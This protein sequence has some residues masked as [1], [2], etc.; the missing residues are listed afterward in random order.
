MTNEK[1]N[2][3]TYTRTIKLFNCG[4]GVCERNP[5]YQPEPQY[6]EFTG[7]LIEQLEEISPFEGKA[8]FSSEDKAEMSKRKRTREYYQK[9]AESIQKNNEKDD[10]CFYRMMQLVKN[11]TAGQ[12][13]L[14]TFVLLAK[15]AME[16]GLEISILE[17]KKRAK[18]ERLKSEWDKIQDTLGK[19]K[20]E[21]ALACSIGIRENGWFT[22]R[23][24]SIADQSPLFAMLSFLNYLKK[25]KWIDK[26]PTSN[27]NARELLD[28][29]L[30]QPDGVEEVFAIYGAELLEVYRASLEMPTKTRTYRNDHARGIINDQWR[31]TKECEGSYVGKAGRG[32]VDG[33]EFDRRGNVKDCTNPFNNVQVD[34]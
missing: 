18:R 32:F 34:F 15:Y 20:H 6:C 33:I 10:E 13:H 16:Q 5:N 9:E 28:H 31:A 17:V 8:V 1:D 24:V 22:L 12:K 14:M 7:E 29:Y 26:E 23:I 2:I 25:N 27:E 3:T 11:N 21:G 30:L 19:M 4:F